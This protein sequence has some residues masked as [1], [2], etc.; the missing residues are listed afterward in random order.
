MPH[1]TWLK[2]EETVGP[3][4]ARMPSKSADIKIQFGCKVATSA[5]AS[6]LLSTLPQFSSNPFNYSADVSPASDNLFK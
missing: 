6:I 1:F 2:P 5:P 4:L 3:V